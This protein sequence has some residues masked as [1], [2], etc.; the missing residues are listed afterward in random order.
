MRLVPSHISEKML[1]QIF[2]AFSQSVLKELFKLHDIQ[3][4]LSSS[5]HIQYGL[6]QY[7]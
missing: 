7:D 5:T 3:R 1:A 4:D 6:I 2:V